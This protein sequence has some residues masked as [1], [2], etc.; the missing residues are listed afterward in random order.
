MKYKY[1]KI[2]QLKYKEKSNFKNKQMNKKPP[3]YKVVYYPKIMQM[4]S[5]FIKYKNKKNFNYKLK[6]KNKFLQHLNLLILTNRQ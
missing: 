6:N 1:L 3:K 5:K 4:K 2:K